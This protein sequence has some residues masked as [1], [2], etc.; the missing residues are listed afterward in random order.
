MKHRS[1]RVLDRSVS[2]PT[3]LWFQLRCIVWSFWFPASSREIISP[4]CLLAVFSTIWLVKRS[5]WSGSWWVLSRII[6]E[7][8]NLKIS[9][10]DCATE[11]ETEL[12]NYP[13]LSLV[14]QAIIGSCWSLSFS[15]AFSYLNARKNY[16]LFKLW[17]KLTHEL[18]ENSENDFKVAGLSQ[19]ENK[20]F[21]LMEN[22]LNQIWYRLLSWYIV[23]IGFTYS[24][25]LFFVKLST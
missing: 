7:N 18:P 9:I 24:S 19:E 1:L 23:L 20:K 6:T 11:T 13:F 8:L 5:F 17:V 25:Q 10:W 22:N 15:I 3:Y 21:W 2:Y 16:L 14:I 4:S 12:L